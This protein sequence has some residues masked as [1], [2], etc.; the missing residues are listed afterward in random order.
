MHSWVFCQL[1]SE[2]SDLVNH[3][4]TLISLPLFQ[5][6]LSKEH[7]QKLDAVGC[8]QI[9]GRW[10]QK[11]CG[12]KS[13]IQPWVS[14]SGQMQMHLALKQ[15]CESFI[16]VAFENCCTVSDD[17]LGGKCKFP[18]SLAHREQCS[19]L[20]ASYQEVISN[21]LLIRKL[22]KEKWMTWNSLHLLHLPGVLFFYPCL[23]KTDSRMDPER[24]IRQ[25]GRTLRSKLQTQKVSRHLR[26]EVLKCL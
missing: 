21:S 25:F 19:A 5:C 23:G 13:E 11:R 16:C 14:T 1:H 22:V 24:R 17:Y 6:G 2:D 3:F 7:F 8:F 18:L 20:L 9:R 15:F 4:R 12:S 10:A 26:N